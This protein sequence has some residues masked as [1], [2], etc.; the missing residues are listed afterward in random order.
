MRRSLR[1]HAGVWAMNIENEIQDI[2]GLPC[3]L[4]LSLLNKL[5]ASRNRKAL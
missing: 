5:G 3:P 2:E 4:P 1:E